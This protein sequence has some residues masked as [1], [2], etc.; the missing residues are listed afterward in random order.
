MKIITVFNKSNLLNSA[1]YSILLTF[2][3]CVFGPIEMF[4]ANN[5]VLWFS[6]FDVLLVSVITFII[7][8]VLLTAFIVLLPEKAKGFV[9]ALIFGVGLATYIQGNYMQINYGVLDGNQVEWENF[10]TWAVVNSSIWAVCVLGP[11]V[12]N[13]WKK[14]LIK[15]A[16]KLLSIFII[17]VQISTIA[18]LLVTTP[19]QH[20]NSIVVT[21]EG[22]L[23]LSP[24]KNIVVF[25]L[26]TFDA[27]FM[28]EILETSPEHKE[29]FEDFTYYRNTLG[30]YP[31][32]KAALPFLLTGQA[33]KNEMPYAK[34]I[35]EAH[36][37]ALLNIVPKENDY[38]VGV[39]T[40]PTFYDTNAPHRYINA[41]DAGYKISSIKMFA[42][43]L[44]QFTT[45]K[46]S[47][48][49]LKRFSWMYS[50]DFDKLRALDDKTYTLYSLSNEGFM[51]QLSDTGISSSN[52]SPSFRFYHLFGSHGPYSHDE[53]LNPLEKD[54][55][56]NVVA[57]SQGA[58]KLVREY[59]NQLKAN[60]I[61][62]NTMIIVTA[63][64]GA[65][66]LLRQNP[67]LMIKNFDESKPFK[68]SDIPVSV[69]NIMPTIANAIT[70]TTKYEKS[71]ESIEENEPIERSYLHY[72]WDGNWGSLYMPDMTE[73]IWK[74][75]SSNT[76]SALYTG[77]RYTYNGIQNIMPVVNSSITIDFSINGEH[78]KDLALPS[79]DSPESLGRWSTKKSNFLFFAEKNQALQ[80]SFVGNSF[81]PTRKTTVLINGHYICE[82]NPS[83]E[84]GPVT[85]PSAYLNDNGVQTMEF[86]TPDAI[87]P[88]EQ[89]KNED[90]R[91][92][93]YYISEITIS[94]AEESIL[95][96]SSKTPAITIRFAHAGNYK[97]FPLSDWHAEEESGRWTTSAS[98]MQFF[99]NLDIPQDIQIS[100][101]GRSLDPER[102]TTLIVNG[103]RLEVV[104]P[105]KLMT[106]PAAYLNDN[107]VQLLELST[108]NATSP[109]ALGVNEDTRIL[110]FT[111]TEIVISVVE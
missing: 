71:I 80:I 75:H 19:P 87:S 4:L 30:M 100:V 50:G 51:K 40:L 24:D 86:S 21:T 109:K 45:V 58:L 111:I 11:V 65:A 84:T 1:L 43:K 8:F 47:P 79:F 36:Q 91:I 77:N 82:L 60:G 56:G 108:P 48:H 41:V 15:K 76:D 39:Y 49:V 95:Q 25:V 103:H 97:F 57:Q 93:G 32:T 27:A 59:I 67:I 96:L 13:A 31:T 3:F 72:N 10:R 42:E 69:E 33:Y 98:S 62:E 28:D 52:D 18:I 35:K 85:I 12:F 46:Y 73:Y 102:E 110:G 101:I 107:G 66:T 68:I 6:L 22:L 64:H 7:L 74:S 99:T 70:G 78:F 89:G 2:T 16:V 63:D 37:K 17:S 92:L 55:S 54:D 26:D 106:I 20:T 90:G 9:G 53:N 61:Y 104:V 83:K 14:N 38:A 34:Y 29:Y 105:G 81:D 88:R 44:V 5:Q 23:E 94:V